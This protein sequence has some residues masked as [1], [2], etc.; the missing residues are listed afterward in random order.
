MFKKWFWGVGIILI[1]GIGYLTLRPS[2]NLALTGDDYLGLWRYN[3]YL[4]GLGRGLGGEKMNNVSYFFTDYG[5][6]DT[7]TAV[8]YNF[9]GF[10]HQLYY[11]ICFILRVIAS[12]SFLWPVYKLTRNRWA[13]LG[14]AGFFLI[15]TTGLEAT[16]WSFNMPSYLAIAILNSWIGYFLI[17]K[18]SNHLLFWSLAA[19]L[20][21]AA[22]IVQPI[23]MVFLPVFV[24]GLEIY[25]LLFNFNLRRFVKAFLR[26]GMYIALTAMIFK[27]TQIGGAVSG[28]GSDTIIKNYGQVIKYIQEKN[29][30]ILLTPV[31]QVGIMVLPNNFM[32]QRLE[33]WGFPRTFR[34]VVIPSYFGLVLGL[35]ILKI[36]KWGLIGSLILGAGWA[37]YVWREYM[38]LGGNSLQPFELLTYLIGGY[39][40]I[41]M[42]LWWWRLKGESHLQLSLVIGLMLML[43]GFMVA[44]L[45]NTGAVFEITSRYLIVPGAGLAWLMA[46]PLAV[47]KR[48]WVFVSL[49]GLLFSLHARTSYSYLFHLSEVR[50]IELTDRLRNSVKGSKDFGDPKIP[51]VY[52]FEGDNP[53]I[54]HHAFIFGW[55]VIS[56]FQFNFSGPWYT[57]A[58]TD[59]WEEVVSAYVDG[60]S[61]KRF[62][63]DPMTTVKMDNVFA[64]R[65]ENRQL[66]DVTEEKRGILKKLK[67]GLR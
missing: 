22:I 56:T 16:D 6:M 26:I 61:L 59:K 39:F 54:L 50:G 40:L 29:F 58:P 3:Y 65:L 25:W 30:R 11:I 64:Y 14:V 42:T 7:L 23:R 4:K 48:K 45:R 19:V 47:Q 21:V 8:I 31:S 20:F 37:G 12:L 5:P 53:E 66:I 10:R 52:Y 57:V 15:T 28:R 18:T 60:K 9:F 62:M 49:F 34:R 44:W 13:S 17:T 33:V 35:I 36:N 27:Y 24:I 41:A 67:K 43:G 51:I 2:F 46:V 38:T 32:Y 1:L 55:P 63:P